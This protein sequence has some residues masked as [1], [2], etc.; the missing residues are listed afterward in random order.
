MHRIS[1]SL[2]LFNKL[3]ANPEKLTIWQ[4]SNKAINAL[5]ALEALNT[6]EM[7]LA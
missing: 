5:N 7:E 3:P 2:S 6:E 4:D 1:V